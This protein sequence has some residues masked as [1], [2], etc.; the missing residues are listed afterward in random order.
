MKKTELCRIEPYLQEVRHLRDYRPASVLVVILHESV[1][2]DE[3]TEQ[4]IEN[5]EDL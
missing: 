4:F 1:M 2:N 3:M 5:L